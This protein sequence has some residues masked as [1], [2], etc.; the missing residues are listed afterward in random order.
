MV[1]QICC[2]RWGTPL[3]LIYG[4]DERIPLC[5]PDPWVMWEGLQP[6]AGSRKVGTW[7]TTPPG[8][9]RPTGK[10]HVMVAVSFSVRYVWCCQRGW[11]KTCWS[12]FFT[13]HSSLH[14]SVFSILNII[15]NM[16]GESISFKWIKYMF[17]ILLTKVIFF[18]NF[19]GFWRYAMV[20]YEW[21]YRH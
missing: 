20:K 18:K 11:T 9:S 7:S 17:L 4:T 1:V 19:S 10:V 3:G 6:G 2:G 8:P 14:R 13:D 12:K 16:V 21:S 15:I 5:T